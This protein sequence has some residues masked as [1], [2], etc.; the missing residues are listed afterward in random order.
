MIV[1]QKLSSSPEVAVV[2]AYPRGPSPD[3]CRGHA[4]A[5]RPAVNTIQAVPL[6][7]ADPVYGL[8]GGRMNLWYSQVP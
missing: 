4:D 3:M 8:S 5:L 2:G 7:E 1:G 6:P